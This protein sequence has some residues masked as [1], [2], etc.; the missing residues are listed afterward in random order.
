MKKK[1]PDEK[2]SSGML[3]RKN[4]LGEKKNRQKR[5]RREEGRKESH[6]ISETKTKRQKKRGS[7]KGEG[8]RMRRIVGDDERE[9]QREPSTIW[10]MGGNDWFP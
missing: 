1:K 7:A 9:G 4:V 5:G 2:K 10:G 8:G 6:N 3:R